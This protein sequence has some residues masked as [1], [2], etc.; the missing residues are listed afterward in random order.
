MEYHKFLNCLISTF[1]QS[2]TDQKKKK[3]FVKSHKLFRWGIRQAA[4]CVHTHTN[5]WKVVSAIFAV[6]TILLSGHRARIIYFRSFEIFNL[7]Y[8][9]FCVIS[10]LLTKVGITSQ[11]FSSNLHSPT[12]AKLF[13][14]V[15]KFFKHLRS[16]I[17]EASKNENLLS[18]PPNK[19]LGACLRCV[20]NL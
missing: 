16:E 8:K 6:K 5:R 7:R 10:S 19:S 18:S 3:N 15:K 12:K 1:A 2:Q 14:L 11:K 20:D 4:E 17:M 13:V 9:W